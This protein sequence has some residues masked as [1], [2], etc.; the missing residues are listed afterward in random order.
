MS[1]PRIAGQPAPYSLRSRLLHAMILGA[2]LIGGAALT[3]WLDEDWPL[4]VSGVVVV[5][6]LAG[7]IVVWRGFRWRDAWLAATV[8]WV[9]LLSAELV[10]RWYESRPGPWPVI[11]EPSADDSDNYFVTDPDLGYALKAGGV[12]PSRLFDDAGVIYDVTYHAEDHG[13]RVTPSSASAGP[14]VAFFGCS[15]TFGEGVSDAETLPEFFAAATHGRFRIL[16]LALHGY[17][18]H[19]MLRAIEIGRY[20]SLFVA[21]VAFVYLAVSWQAERASRNAGWNDEGP[22]YVVDGGSVQ[23]TGTFRDAQGLFTKVGKH[24]VLVDF[25][26]RRVVRPLKSGDLDLFVGIL[27]RADSLLTARYGVGLTVLY[28]KEP[29]YEPNLKAAGW[30]DDSIVR[31]LRGRHVTVLNGD[32]PDPPAEIPHLYRFRRDGHPTAAAN[33]ARSDSLLQHLSL[34]SPRGG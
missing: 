25:L 22:R 19:Q 6:V 33:R 7:G 20:D 8:S 28:V 9:C 14:V 17:G 1:A 5:A 30:S 15:Y 4:I 3:A 16:N 24:S 21:P 32:T 12:A 10:I 26:R 18:P 29:T 13:I 34:P 2:S 31:A 23:F 11:N 27:A